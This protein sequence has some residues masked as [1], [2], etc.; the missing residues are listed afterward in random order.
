MGPTSLTPMRSAHLG[1]SWEALP[2]ASRLHRPS[3]CNASAHLGPSW[4]ALPDVS[5][6]HPTPRR[7]RPQHPCAYLLFLGRHSRVP[8]DEGRHHT[9]RG[10]NAKAQRGHIQQ[11]Q[12]LDL[13]PAS[14]CQDGCLH[15]TKFGLATGFEIPV[16][17]RIAASRW[18]I[19]RGG[20]SALLCVTECGMLW[21]QCQ[22]P[23]KRPR[24]A[25]VKQLAAGRDT[26]SN[27]ERLKAYCL[28]QRPFNPAASPQHN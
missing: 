10:F 1:P 5:R 4:E 18:P 2:D 24:M 26:D 16:L 28:S 12:L 25:S 23:K 13:L 14:T 17:Y 6:L 9:A 27:L 8:G 22:S 19:C 20:D 7:R 3:C 21:Q 15:D 11:Q